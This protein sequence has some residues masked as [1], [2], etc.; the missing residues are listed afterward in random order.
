MFKYIRFSP[1]ALKELKIEKW[2]VEINKKIR[3]LWKPFLKIVSYTV[4]CVMKGEPA[5]KYLKPFFS[6][7]ERPEDTIIGQ[8]NLEQI[9]EEKEKPSP[10]IL[11]FTK[12]NKLNEE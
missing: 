8:L 6:D 1:A 5:N 10:P 9:V 4:F 7:A 3:D 12:I 11:G 2:T